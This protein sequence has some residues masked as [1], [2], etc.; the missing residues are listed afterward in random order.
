MANTRIISSGRGRG[1]IARPEAAEPLLADGW[2]AFLDGPLAGPDRPA[3]LELVKQG[4]GRNIF[5]FEAAGKTYYMKDYGGSGLW[6]RV[7]A[8]A[9]RGPGRREWD[10]LEAA[11]AAGLDVPEAVALARGPA[12]RLVTAGV[13]GERL[14]EYLFS[15]YFEPQAGDPPYPGA[16]PPELVA[17][18]RR[19]RVPT[20]G[21]VDPKTLS[22]RLADVV[23]RLAEARLYLP[24]LHP[25][26][27]LISGGAGTW[28]LWLVD[29]AE[30]V[31]PAPAD[32]VLRHLVQ[33]EHFFEPIASPVERIRCHNRVIQLL[34]DGPDARQVALGTSAYRRRFYRR[35]DRRTRRESKYFKRLAAGDWR[36][37]A[38]ADRASALERLLEAGDPTAAAGAKVVKEGRTAGVW[39]VAFD[40]AGGHATLFFKRHKRASGL[41]RS[42]S[43]AAFRK[44]HALLV[45]GIA[46]ARPAGAVDKRRGPWLTDTL[47][48]TEPVEGEPLSDWLRAGPPATERRRMAR[49]VARLI[50]RMHEAG[51]SHRDLKAPNI[52]VAPA[53]GPGAQPVLVDLDGLAYKGTVSAR[54]RAQN[55]MRLSVSLDEW[56]VARQTDRL[57]FLRAYLAPAGCLAPIT[58]RRRR[59]RAEPG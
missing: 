18:F 2:P 44:G 1:W 6:R 14:D 58:T 28:R 11:R 5:R 42:R 32:A 4:R 59:G 31:R 46:T 34:G 20:E 35:R 50:R 19:R 54:R 7:R 40:D 27:I 29:L 24:D 51:F 57:R 45:R 39:R 22:W 13:P 15:R 52:L 9:G 33:L 3:H 56:G 30:A 48:A 43:V 25:G 16:R 49:R 53:H 37:W 17:V 12:E 38:T 23:A 10:A 26:N 41:G 36:G 21:T 47:L 55:L 8:M